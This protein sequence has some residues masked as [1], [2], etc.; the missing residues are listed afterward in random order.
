MHSDCQLELRA[1]ST[2]E[3]MM[4]KKFDDYVNQ[5]MF[6]DWFYSYSDDYSVYKDGQRKSEELL[7]K[8]RV[9]PAFD[10]VYKAIQLYMQND[11]ITRNFGYLDEQI[12]EARSLIKE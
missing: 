1:K 3:L 11:P 5:L 7:A 4:Q 12:K 9:H 10:K 8:T 2:K 6:F